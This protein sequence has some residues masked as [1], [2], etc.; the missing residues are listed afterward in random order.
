MYERNRYRLF[1]IKLTGS[2]RQ[3]CMGRETRNIVN[4]VRA[5]KDAS[6]RTKAIQY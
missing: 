4:Q 6:E 3:L 1:S 5:E 2:S